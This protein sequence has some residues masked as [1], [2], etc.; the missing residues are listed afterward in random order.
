M[1]FLKVNCSERMKLL[2]CYDSLVNID[3]VDQFSVITSTVLHSEQ[4]MNKLVTM[5]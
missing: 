2:N 3:L 1:V 4:F 5:Q